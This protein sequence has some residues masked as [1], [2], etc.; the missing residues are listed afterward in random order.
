MINGNRLY[1]L[2]SEVVDKYEDMWK[3][4]AE[5]KK[6]LLGPAGKILA[7]G[8]ATEGAPQWKDTNNREPCC[9]HS[10]PGI[11]YSEILHSFQMTCVVNATEM[12]GLMAMEAIKAKKAYVGITHTEQHAVMV[13]DQCIRLVWKEFQN[14]KSSIYKPALSESCKQT[15]VSNVKQFV[16][17]F[18]S[19]LFGM[20]HSTCSPNLLQP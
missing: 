13:R 17:L 5:K 12:D 9:Y 16:W 2:R 14:P 6:A 18:G 1:I 11:F 19:P 10:M 15:T 7:G 20:L 4:K 8:A 3:L